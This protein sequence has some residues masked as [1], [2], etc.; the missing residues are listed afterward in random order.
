MASKSATDLQQAPFTP[1]LTNRVGANKPAFPSRKSEPS[2]QPSWQLITPLLAWSTRLLPTP[3]Q[4]PLSPP[5][6][7]A[8]NEGTPG[9]EE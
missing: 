1:S 8:L 3:R 7:E 9:V 6:P 2:L 5:L 4:Y